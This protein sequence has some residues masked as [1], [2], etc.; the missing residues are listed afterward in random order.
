MNWNG[1]VILEGNIGVGKSTFSRALSEALKELGLNA[2]AIPEPDE[3][4]NP[5]LALYY[6]DPAAHAYEMQCHLLHKRFEST[7]YAVAG[8][9]SGRGWYILDRSY[10]GDICFARVQMKDGFFTPEQ[11]ASYLSAHK[12]MRRFLEPPTAAIFLK[13]STDTLNRRIAER[14]RSCESG[15]A[16]AYLESLQDEIDIL[17]AEMSRR[18]RVIHLDWNA[19]QTPAQLKESARAIA[20]RL[21]NLVTDDFDF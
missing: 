15:I 4:T 21:A 13:A 10:Y 20:M 17:E 3:N 9:R 5:F 19:D 6:K 16:A 1:Y 18:T 12:S 7:Q 2:E 11:Y 8:A 14:S